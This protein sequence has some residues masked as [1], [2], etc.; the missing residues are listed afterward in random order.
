MT[1]QIDNG[2]ILCT[3]QT[4]CPQC[5][6]AGVVLHASLTDLL[7]KAPG[8]WTIR[9]CTSVSCGLGWVD[10]VPITDQLGKLYSSYYT[11]SGDDTS[12]RSVGLKRSLKTLAG[13]VLFWKRAAFWTDDV[14][15]QGMK[16]GALLDIG[17]GNGS[18]LAAAAQRG[19]DAHGIDFDADAVAAARQRPGVKV[20]VG[21]LLEQ[22]FPAESFDAITLNNVIEHLPNPRETIAECRRLLKPAG[23][24]VVITPNLDSLG[25][26]TFQEHWRGLEPPRH[27]FMF[28]P[29]TLRSLAR[30]EGFQKISAFSAPGAVETMF[31]GS[32]EVAR[33]DG[34]GS[35]VPDMAT[36]ATLAKRERALCLLGFPRGEWSVL[37]AHA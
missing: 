14:H 31:A 28:T 1:E 4:T 29:T 16:P 34:R 19:W 2:G 36:L 32:A 7:F 12:F 35:K 26:Q 11:H 17:C 21:G 30:R 37:V 33:L 27:L 5:A 20:W 23:R 13:F 18:F 25:H 6:S 10:P 3:S 15:L 24:L 9:R 8:T 22:N